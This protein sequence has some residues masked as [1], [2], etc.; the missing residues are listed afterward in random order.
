MKAEPLAVL[1]S[2]PDEELVAR[3]DGEAERTQANANYYL[4]ELARR[5][6]H[7][8]TRAILE[9]TRSV[10]RMT[11]VITVATVVNMV[12]AII[13]VYVAARTAGLLIS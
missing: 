8:Q 12:A 6:Q 10:E 11:K 13:A 2:M 9:Y 4:A 3:H 5:E 7:R 1:R